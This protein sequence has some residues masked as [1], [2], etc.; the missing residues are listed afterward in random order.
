M[1]TAQRITERM[2]ATGRVRSKDSIYSVV[3]DDHNVH[4][5]TEELLDVWWHELPA[6]DKAALYELHLDGVLEGSEAAA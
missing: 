1:L 5:L 2:E 3:M 6:E 4:G